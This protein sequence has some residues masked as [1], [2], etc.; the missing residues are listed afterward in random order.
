MRVY[1]AVVFVY[2]QDRAARIYEDQL[3]PVN[4]ECCVG[5]DF[6]EIRL[7]DIAVISHEHDFVFGSFERG[8][9]IENRISAAA[10]RPDEI[11]RRILILIAVE[12]VVAVCAVKSGAAAA[13]ADLIVF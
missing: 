1:L 5:T 2:K 10:D 7:G 3:V 4:R 11:I 6:I 12:F 9:V 13:D 8:A